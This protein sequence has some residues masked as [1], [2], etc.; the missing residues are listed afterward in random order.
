MM[1][2]F[3]VTTTGVQFDGCKGV[4]FDWF[5]C[6]RGDPR[7]YSELITDYDP[8][9]PI[10][11]YPEAA[12]DG[13]FTEAEAVALKAYLDREHGHEG[14]TTIKE[15]QLPI[16]NNTLGVSAIPVGGGTDFLMLYKE[17]AYDLEF[18]VEGYYDLR[19]RELIDGSD[20][21]PPPPGDL[22]AGQG[23]THADQRRGRPRQPVHINQR[24]T[25]TRGHGPQHGELQ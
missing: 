13:F 25:A 4:E 9:A 6:G 8:A 21:F 1:K 7:P 12:I 22:G 2:L 11:G 16:P 5:R 23:G 24:T 20:V 19:G 17:P 14:V 10:A 3:H 18:Q 15:I